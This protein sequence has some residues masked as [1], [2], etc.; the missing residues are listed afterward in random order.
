MN[1]IKIYPNLSET[2]SENCHP[3]PLL[4]FERIM[5]RS[6]S[7]LIELKISQ[8]FVAFFK[9]PVNRAG[10]IDYDSIQKFN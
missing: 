3:P 5:Q 7:E 2:F 1:L 9:S 6:F 8:N 4:V 10:L